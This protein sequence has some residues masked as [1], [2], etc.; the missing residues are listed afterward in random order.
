MNDVA[1][2]PDYVIWSFEHRQ[3]WG[4]D[5]CGYTSDLSLAGRYTAEDAGDIVTSSI[6]ADEVA[7]HQLVAEDRGAPTVTGLWVDA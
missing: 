2:Q 4:P 5:H 1:E 6:M 7:I 3:W